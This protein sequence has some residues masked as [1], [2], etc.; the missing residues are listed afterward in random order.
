MFC[1]EQII[2]PWEASRHGMPAKGV[3]KTKQKTPYAVFF[4][5]DSF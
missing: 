2:P 4:I 5:I 3:W 1:K